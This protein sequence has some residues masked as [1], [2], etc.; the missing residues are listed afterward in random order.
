MMKKLI[1]S[2]VTTIVLF[3]VAVVLLLTGTIG[4]ARA[5]R[6][7]T[8]EYVSTVSMQ[9]IGVTLLE[10][11]KAVAYRN[12]R[13]AADGTWNQVVGDEALLKDL[14]KEKEN[15][16][17][18]TKY[19]EVLAVQNSGNIDQYVRVTV[20]RFWKDTSGNKITTQDPS[21]IKLHL[22]ENSPWILDE[23][24]STEE[25][26]VLYYPAILAV[27]QVSAPFIDEIMVDGS[28]YDFLPRASETEEISKGHYRKTTTYDYTKDGK[29]FGIEVEVDAVQTHNATGA[30]LSAWGKKVSVRGDGSL[31]FQ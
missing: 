17:F 24:A 13:A 5:A 22:P 29:S 11:G 1:S 28:E 12:Y 16:N 19:P 7:S 3:A 2:P 4:G 8:Q 23:D 25:R 21:L 31:S 27:D 15:F 20:Y 30:I 10:N 9:D 6:I 18:S 14:V 26:I